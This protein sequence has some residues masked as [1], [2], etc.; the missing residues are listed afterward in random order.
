MLDAACD[1]ANRQHYPASANYRF[2][3]HRYTAN[4]STA[5]TYRNISEILVPVE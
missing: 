2:N 4:G 5:D 1:P 3:I